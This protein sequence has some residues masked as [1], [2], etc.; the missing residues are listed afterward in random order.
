[1]PILAFYSSFFLPVSLAYFVVLLNSNIRFVRR[2][3]LSAIWLFLLSFL[4]GLFLLNS[5][6]RIG[7]L[8]SLTLLNV[9]LTIGLFLSRSVRPQNRI[10]SQLVGFII[11]GSTLNTFLYIAFGDVSVNFNGYSSLAGLLGYQ[12]ERPL[13]YF[14]NGV[15]HYGIILGFSLVL[16]FC[17]YR[18]ISA[19]S[20]SLISIL[21]KGWMLVHLL[22]LI[23]II[24]SRGALLGLTGAY[25]GSKL[26]GFSR[27]YNYLLLLVPLLI[28]LIGILILVTVTSSFSFARDGSSLFSHRESVWMI[29]ISGLWELPTT[30]LIFGSGASGYINYSFGEEI[31]RFFSDRGNNVGSL[32]N[33]Y[34]QLIYKF[35]LFGVFLFVASYVW[36]IRRL[37]TRNLLFG[38]S[39][40]FSYFFIVSAT[41]AILSLG[42]L[43]ILI[44]LSCYALLTINQH[45][46]SR[47]L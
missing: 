6:Y 34:L 40:L 35:G 32:H 14:S 24:D 21:L 1:M 29:G 17:W 28:P 7:I 13:F 38:L 25:F 15:N 46:K 39:P 16:V 30:K 18:D 27:I 4:G 43:F 9:L 37:A 12:I 26:F 11:L 19:S 8:S 41:E 2:I 45:N 3:K 31:V 10:I 42:Y 20:S 36:V 22:L 44:S 33:A 47:S 5:F 23:F